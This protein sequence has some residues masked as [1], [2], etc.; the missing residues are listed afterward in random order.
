MTHS[1]LAR[2][3]AICRLAR[4]ALATW[5]EAQRREQLETLQGEAWDDHP[6]WKTLP[7]GVRR[8]LSVDGALR[9]PATDPRYDGALLLAI[10]LRF[11][12]VTNEF[13]GQ[14]LGRTVVGEV[15]A[16]V[17]CPCC[18][19]RTLDERGGYDICPVCFWEDD[20][21]DDPG[22]SSGPNH[23][24]LGE[25][26]RNFAAFGAVTRRE[27]A[28]VDPQGPQKYPRA[29]EGPGPSGPLRA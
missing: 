1:P 6:Q 11:K 21:V 14:Q 24:T 28:F 17:A 5:S 3:D 26:R 19:H 22:T 4:A 15:E 12:G 9:G 8:E 20:G 2:A 7:A 27:R 25:A 16:L 18:S 23:L 10:E 13:L 29:P